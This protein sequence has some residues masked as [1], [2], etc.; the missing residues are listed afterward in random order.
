MAFTKE[1]IDFAKLSNTDVKTKLNEFNILL[2]TDEARKIQND[3]LG[4][5]PSMAELIL[6]SIQG[7][8]LKIRS[9]RKMFSNEWGLVAL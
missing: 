1:I 2:T 9:T 8:D 6:F 5:A 4:R 7:L 3:M